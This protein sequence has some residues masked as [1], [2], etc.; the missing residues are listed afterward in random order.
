MNRKQLVTL[1]IVA[2]L[3]IILPLI[4]Y[5]ARQNQDIRNRAQGS[6][7]IGLRFEPASGTF[8]P[9]QDVTINV[10][11]YK[12]ASRTINVS[13]VQSVLN[14]STKFDIVSA[15]CEAPFNGLPFTKINNQAVTFMCA[16]QTGS[17]PVTLTNSNKIFAKVKVRPKSGTTGNAPV[18][19][20]STRVTEAGVPNQAPDVS[21]AGTNST[22]IIRQGN[23]TPTDSITPPVDPSLTP[24]PTVTG[25]PSPTS[26][27]G[28]ANVIFEPAAGNLPPVSAFKILAN[29]GSEKLAFARVAFTFDQTKVNLASEIA[30]NVSLS[31]VVEKTS[32]TAANSSGRAVIVIAAAPADSLPSGQV[33]IAETQFKSMVSGNDTTQVQIDGSDI[34]L[35]NDST[36]VIP[37]SG[38]TL[39][40][41]LGS[42]DISVTPPGSGD[43]TID[44]GEKDSLL[45]KI[46]EGIAADVNL[47]FD[48]PQGN[49]PPDGT[50]KIMMSAPG[51][52]IV[53][54]RVVFTFDNTKVNLASEITTNP[55]MTFIIDKTTQALAN[56]SGRAVIVIAAAPA[57][58]PP[59]GDFEFANMTFTSLTQTVNDKTQVDFDTADMQIVDDS[60]FDTGLT[61][62]VEPLILTLNGTGPGN[63]PLIRFAVT[64]NHTQNNPDMYFK[65]R[66]KDDLFF[67][68]NPNI[69]PSSCEVPGPGEKDYLVPMRFE[70]GAY[71]PV[72]GVQLLDDSPDDINKPK[73]DVTPDGY[74]ALPGLEGDKY[75]TLLLKTSKFRGSRM[76]QHLYLVPGLNPVFDWTADPLEPGDLPDPNNNLGQDCTV[77]SIDISLIVGRIGR[78]DTPSLDIADVNFDAIVNANDVSKVVNTLSTKPDDDL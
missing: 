76:A 31:T 60:S 15:N 24:E 9:G 37:S 25:G 59:S 4:I 16:I 42:S 22:Y 48:P 39:D 17:N 66:V 77:N 21:N 14:T 6:N 53:F 71:W 7:E 57:D 58:T 73:L 38:G 35:V 18:S 75:Y 51:K 41:T 26:P 46:G 23:I 34:Q 8:A 32:M 47:S 20:T 72:S 68:D 5:V 11:V 74:V 78:T 50:F 70:N 64:L 52:N 3:I 13:G 62:S 45:I 65:L 43:Y 30:P 63:E 49:L 55:N 1:L 36:V 12:T 33:G 19:F 40:L 61:Y 29:I 69:P 2:A 67:L 10:A 54:G 27:V 56:S 28:T 44:V